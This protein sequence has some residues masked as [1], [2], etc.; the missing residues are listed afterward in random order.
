MPIT[1]QS[2]LNEPCIEIDN[3]LPYIKLVM[4]NHWPQENDKLKM[5]GSNDT[6]ILKSIST[7]DISPKSASLHNNNDITVENNFKNHL[8]VYPKF[9]KYDNQKSFS[10][11]S[12]FQLR[13]R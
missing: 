1:E 13:I 12:S 3:F 5:I 8:Y 7:S 10:R 6:H 2:S 11:V 4:F 9:L